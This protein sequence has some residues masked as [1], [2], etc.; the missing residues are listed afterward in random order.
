MLMRSLLYVEPYG[1]VYRPAAGAKINPGARPLHRITVFHPDVRYPKPAERWDVLPDDLLQYLHAVFVKDRRAPFPLEILEDGRWT[2]CSACGHEHARALC[3]YCAGAPPAAVREVTRVRG[4]VTSRRVF[5][6]TGTIFEAAFQGGRLVW[7]YQDGESIK[8]ETEE[9]IFGGR[10]RPGLRCRFL[11]RRTLVG[12]GP[13]VVAIENGT[14]GP[15]QAVAVVNGESAFDTNE[16]HLYWVREGTLMRDGDLGPERIGDVL[17]GQTAIWA[18]PTFGFGFY[19]AGQLQVG[20]VFDAERTGLNDRVPMPR[21]TGRLTDVRCIFG[22]DRCWFLTACEENGRTVHRCAVVMR[23]GAVRAVAVAAAGDGS[24]LES[25]GAGCAAGDALLM[26]TDDGLVRIEVSGSALVKTR[27]FPDTEPFVD[28]H[29][30]L[31]AGPDGL[32][33]VDAHEIRKLSLSRAA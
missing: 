7:L 26:P 13:K 29:S 3:P 5:A 1:G 17:A 28:A 8:R 18:G 10:W 23:E 33:V 24:W 27:E 15:P 19:R 30:R 2:R 20:F 31:I 16:R 9:T 6:T 14:P 4:E 32:Y 21:M 22:T 11:P 25:I 12:A